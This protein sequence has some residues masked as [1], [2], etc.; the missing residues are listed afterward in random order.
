MDKYGG[1]AIFYSTDDAKIHEDNITI[2]NQIA[3]T[4]NKYPSL[5]LKISSFTD[6][7]G[8]EDL[9]NNLC[10]NRADNIAKQFYENNVSENKITI[11]LQAMTDDRT[12]DFAHYCVQIGFVDNNESAAYFAN[13]YQIPENEISCY[14]YNKGYSYTISSYETLRE[15]SIGAIEF[16]QNYQIGAFPV[17]IANNKR[18]TDTRYAI[19]RRTELIL[20]Y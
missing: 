9:N 17:I 12:S 18:L 8:T 10:Q 11:D 20:Y 5:K 19:N 15:A 16:N 3:D 6:I 4:L 7:R 1:N 13:K 14:Q 2:I